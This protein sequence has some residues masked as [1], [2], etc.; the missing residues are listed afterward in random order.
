MIENPNSIISPHVL[1][2]DD[3]TR[4]RQLLKRYLLENGYRVTTAENAQDAREKLSGFL[5]DTIVLDVMMPGEDGFELTTSLRKGSDIP[6]ILLTARGDSEDRIKGLE[7]GADDYL[8]K[9]FEPRELILRIDAVLRRTRTSIDEI[10]IIKLGEH[11]FDPGR[12]ELN[13][14][15]LQIHLTTAETEI[16]RLLSRSPGIVISRTDLAA[17]SPGSASD[18]AVD[19][20]VT[21][22][23]RKIEPDPKNPKYIKT[24]WGGGYALWPD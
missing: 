4:L 7:S 1:V 18:R 3:D 10:S 13:K 19:V 23:R 9:P 16:L 14:G 22:I 21:R 24:V 6:I 15:N 17:V 5:F 11:E 20:H 8:P 2:V 12:G